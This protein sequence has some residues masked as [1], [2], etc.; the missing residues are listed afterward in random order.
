VTDDPDEAERQRI[1]EADR[2]RN[3]ELAAREQAAVDE[4]DV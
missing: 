3:R 4:E 1:L 2:Q